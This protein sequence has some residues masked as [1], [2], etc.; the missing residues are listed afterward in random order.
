[1]NLE[2]RQAWI[3]LHDAASTI[4]EQGMDW[5]ARCDLKAALDQSFEAGI[6]EVA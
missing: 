5:R 3:A 2:Q 6:T 4:I 1:M